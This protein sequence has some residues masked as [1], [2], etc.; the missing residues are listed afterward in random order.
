MQCS[1]ATPSLPVASQSSHNPLHLV[2]SLEI[3]DEGGSLAK[4]IMQKVWAPT[5]V[6]GITS[7]LKNIDRLEP[8]GG[9]LT[10][11][12]VNPFGESGRFSLVQNADASDGWPKGGT[13][14]VLSG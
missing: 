1:Q 6:G 4:H 13:D 12:L 2:L 7:R 9:A 10:E 14:A 3:D 11:E 8:C 5:N